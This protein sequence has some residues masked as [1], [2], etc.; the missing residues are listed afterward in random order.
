L[1]LVDL[2][3]VDLVELD[4]VDL[5]ELDRVDLVELDRVD[6]VELDRLD[7]VDLDRV[8]LP[9]SLELLELYRLQSVLLNRGPCSDEDFERL[10]ESTPYVGVP[11]EDAEVCLPQYVWWGRRRDFADPDSD[12]VS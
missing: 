10:G 3:R 12:T 5:V 8:D 2:D 7:L 4:R 6:L 11:S 9:E 1:D